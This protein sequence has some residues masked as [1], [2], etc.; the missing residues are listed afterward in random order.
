M[1][2]QSDVVRALYLNTILV[3]SCYFESGARYNLCM[4]RVM[5]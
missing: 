3:S 1:G 4:E 5:P 2:Y